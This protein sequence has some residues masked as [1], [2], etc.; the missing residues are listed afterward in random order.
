[1]IF[2]YMWHIIFGEKPVADFRNIEY[3]KERFNGHI[4]SQQ[5]KLL[6]GGNI[7]L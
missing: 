6:S 4:P 5:H 2:E 3:F 7:I 1:M